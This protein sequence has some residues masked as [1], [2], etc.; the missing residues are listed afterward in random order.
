MLVAGSLTTRKNQY[1]PGAASAWTRGGVPPEG[2]TV[3]EW[4]ASEAASSSTRGNG[5]APSGPVFPLGE[6][7][8]PELPGARPEEAREPTSGTANDHAVPRW[9]WRAGVPPRP[10]TCYGRLVTHSLRGRASWRARI[11]VHSSS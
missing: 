5:W 3:G 8:Q 7:S 10:A 1:L 4:A 9:S 6:P 2:S 11:I